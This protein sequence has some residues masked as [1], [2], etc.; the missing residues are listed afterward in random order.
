M[1]GIGDDRESANP[2]VIASAAKQSSLRTTKL[3][4]FVAS[5]LAMT[6]LRQQCR[7]RRAEKPDA[8]IAT[9]GLPHLSKRSSGRPNDAR[10]GAKPFCPDVFRRGDRDDRVECAKE[11]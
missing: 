1:R 5:L 2:A 11:I 6:H 3:D 7:F 4:C 8:C 9:R 10:I